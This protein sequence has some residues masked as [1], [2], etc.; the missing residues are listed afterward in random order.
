VRMEENPVPLEPGMVISNEPAIYF[1]G[2]YGIRTENVVAVKAWK[3]G[4]FGQFNEFETF[5]LVPI[6]TSCVDPKLLTAA[7][8]EWLNNYNA[9]V[10]E[11]ISPLL[12]S[13]EE[14]N[15]LSN[16]TATIG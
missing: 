2:R 5:T 14:A 6:A 12:N 9:R 8:L 13:E 16:V 4:E 3:E 15:W 7:E 10:F 11:Q 1:A